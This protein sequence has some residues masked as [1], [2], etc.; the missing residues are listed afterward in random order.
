MSTLEKEN[1][2]NLD[3]MNISNENDINAIYLLI[4]IAKHK[5]KILTFPIIFGIL[6]YGVSL[7]IPNTY[8]ANTKILPP[9][10]SQSTASA[11]LS[12]LGGLAG[13]AGAALGIK[14]PNELYIA[15]L[16]SRYLND[17][18]IQKFDLQKKYDQKYM[19]NTRTILSSRSSISS[20]KD[21]IISIDFDDHDPH[22]AAEIANA[23][24]QELTE[25]TSKLA[26]TEA[27]QRRVFYETQLE[28]AKNNLS[29]LEKTLSSSIE[30]NGVTSVD[31]TSKVTLETIA[32]LRAA[33]S[34]KQ[35]QLKSLESFVTPNSPQY[36]RVNQ[37]ILG[38]QEEL[39][40]L[41]NGSY[42]TS[43]S[44][45][46]LTLGKHAINKEKII[47]NNNNLQ[48]L[49]DL[50]YYQMLHEM[51]SKQYEIAR[52]DEAKDIPL[53]QILDKA[54]DPEIKVK[55]QRSL[56]AIIFAMFGLLLGIGT[57]FLSERSVSSSSTQKIRDLKNI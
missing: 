40:K 8:R 12:Q 20:G 23:Y 46:N 42:N 26:L 13:S 7:L 25:L 28:R 31:I 30:E 27:S 52:L 5:F 29:E 49:R 21:G 37:E 41:E 57:A 39:S 18:L 51:L 43:K 22:F 36:K 33:I 6:A 32:K 53:I 44:S 17:K 34:L 45:E 14:N 15:L 47:K 56:I 3:D 1:K 4:I 50:K 35:I 11:M 10:Q 24:V 54:I 9:Q 48:L 2:Q 55:P 16:K 38:M 19:E